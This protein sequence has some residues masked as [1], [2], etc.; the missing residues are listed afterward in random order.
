MTERALT[1]TGSTARAWPGGARGPPRGALAGEPRGNQYRSLHDLQQESESATHWHLKPHFRRQVADGPAKSDKQK[2]Q[3]FELQI[4]LLLC[5]T[6]NYGKIRRFLYG[7][8]SS[9]KL[10]P[11][12]NTGRALMKK[13]LACMRTADVKQDTIWFRE[14]LRLPIRFSRRKYPQP[15]ALAP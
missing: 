8:H 12:T 2:Y 6:S 10:F 11:E 4:S 3:L 7:G 9:M 14:G 13:P 1:N 5:A 15:P